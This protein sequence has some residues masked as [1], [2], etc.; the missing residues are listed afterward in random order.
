MTEKAQCNLLLHMRQKVV[1]W[2]L[3]AE[4]AQLP[5]SRNDLPWVTVSKTL[6][7]PKAFGVATNPFPQEF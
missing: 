4:R 5:L 3:M 2:L 7:T 6:P 1:D